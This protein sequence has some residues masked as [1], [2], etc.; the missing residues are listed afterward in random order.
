MIAF[1]CWRPLIVCHIG[2]FMVGC[3]LNLNYIIYILAIFHD[4]QQ[5]VSTQSHTDTSAGTSD[6]EFVYIHVHLHTVINIF[7]LSLKIYHPGAK[8]L[9]VILDF[10]KLPNWQ[11]YIM[12]ID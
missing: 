9:R 12:H 10:S 3:C 11:V 8:S 2:F 6:S 1:D 7:I 5:H 4:I